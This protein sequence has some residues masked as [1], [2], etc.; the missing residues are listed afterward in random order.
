MQTVFKNF[1]FGQ[2]SQ[3]VLT[4]IVGNFKKLQFLPKFDSHWT[5]L[6][7]YVK[8]N[9]ITEIWIQSWTKLLRQI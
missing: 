4:M 2:L 8:E 3:Q 5:Y 9:L 1:N 6:S 7:C